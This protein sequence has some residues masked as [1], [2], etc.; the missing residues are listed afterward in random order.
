MCVCVFRLMYVAGAEAMK[1]RIATNTVKPLRRK[2]A[3]GVAAVSQQALS[4]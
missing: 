3:T 2:K 1:H 4:L